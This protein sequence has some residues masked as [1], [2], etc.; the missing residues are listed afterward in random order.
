MEHSVTKLATAGQLVR[1][2]TT[3]SARFGALLLLFMSAT[4]SAAEQVLEEVV[5]TAQRRDQSLQSVPISVTAL[6]SGD[7]QEL[8]L[9]DSVSIGDRVPNLNFKT[10]GG[11]LNITIRGV[12]N[13]DFN[14]AAISPVSVYRDG[15]V[16]GANAPQVFSLFDMDRIEVLRGPQGTLFGKNTTG[17]ALTYYSKKPG[18]EV[19]GRVRA[20]YGRFDLVHAEAAAT[21][22]ISENFKLRIAGVTRQRNGFADNIFNDEGI[23]E[24]DENAVRAIFRY[25]PENLDAL[26]QIG[27]GKAKNGLNHIKAVGTLPGGTNLV[28]W[29]YPDRDDLDNWNLDAPSHNEIENTYAILDISYYLDSFTIKSITGY[30]DGSGDYLQDSDASPINVLYRHINL[31]ETEQFTQELQLQYSDEKLDAVAG[32]YYFKEDYDYFLFLEFFGFASPFG[33]SRLFTNTRKNEAYAAFAQGTYELSD[34]VRATAGIRYTYDDVKASAEEFRLFGA[35][36]LNPSPGELVEWLPFVEDKTDSDAVDWR[37]ALEFDLQDDVMAYGS[38]T[39]GFKAGGSRAA[40]VVNTPEELGH[41][42]PEELIAYEVGI[43]STA[44]EQRLRINASAFYYDY[45][46][47]QVQSVRQ[48]ENNLTVILVENAADAEISGLEVEI[49]ALPLPGLELGLNLGVVDGDYKNYVSG[50][51]DAAGNLIDFSGNRLP[52][53]PKFNMSANLGYELNIDGFALRFRA[54]YSH[55][56]KK[57]T[58]SAEDP[59]VNTLK[60]YE[61]LNLR[62][63][64][65]PANSNWEITAWGQNVTGEKYVTESL[66]LRSLGY[67]SYQY[68]EHEPTWGVD[69]VYRF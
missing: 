29:T 22:P 43:K 31:A 63:S 65:V 13:N 46:D 54:D 21:V 25:T 50:A 39:K 26:L 48:G 11:T 57:F 15:V 64:V 14:T 10:I 35:F 4:T 69:V 47:L 17:G 36:N 51:V 41:V 59:L 37:L 24:I 18:D 68:G 52:N 55:A 40:G 12:G 32:L 42:D 19:D 9:A 8:N 45:T 67:V 2:A 66:D 33:L 38:I 16:V 28:G 30:D 62:L 60:G 58:N 1:Q 6:T 23:G 7:I 53:T 49:S 44:L 20:T 5:V 3:G 27:H 61:L 56:C 34:R